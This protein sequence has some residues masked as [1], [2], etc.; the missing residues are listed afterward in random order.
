[1]KFLE[2]PE[3]GRL[4]VTGGDEVVVVWCF[5]QDGGLEVWDPT[6]DEMKWLDDQLETRT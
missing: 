5:D 6:E 2:H 1:M 3:V 4:V